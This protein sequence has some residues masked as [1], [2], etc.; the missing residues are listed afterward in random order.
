LG[1]AGSCPFCLR[2]ELILATPI[3][4]THWRGP[5]RPQGCPAPWRNI[6]PT[7]GEK[8]HLCAFGDFAVPGR[9]L[10]QET[11]QARDSRSGLATERSCTLS[12]KSIPSASSHQGQKKRGRKQ[13]ADFGDFT[14][15]F[16]RFLGRRI[17]D[18][19]ESY[20]L[21]AA[22]TKGVPQTDKWLIERYLKR[23]EGREAGRSGR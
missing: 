14:L 12:T 15:A 16:G 22:R 20:L 1:R 6:C 17:R 18:V 13:P 2:G 11:S 7:R 3:G 10:T 21:W 5:A 23:N 8:I 19:P 4:R 9:P